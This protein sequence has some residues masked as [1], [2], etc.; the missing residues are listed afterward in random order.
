MKPA[1][2]ALKLDVLNHRGL[3]VK[4]V[5]KLS[6]FRQINKTFGHEHD[7]IHFDLPPVLS[8]LFQLH[9]DCGSHRKK[10]S[11]NMAVPRTHLLGCI[12]NYYSTSRCLVFFSFFSFSH[13]LA[14]SVTVVRIFVQI[15]VL[16]FLTGRW[17][18]CGSHIALSPPWLPPLTEKLSCTIIRSVK[19][20]KLS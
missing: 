6:S 14:F 13:F 3:R 12:S 7:A 17:Q 19:R 8:S 16:L 4:K 15:I 1:V 20:K 11:T 10:C 5:L 18:T 9:P 2:T